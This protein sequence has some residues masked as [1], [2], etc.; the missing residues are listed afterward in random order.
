MK[1]IRINDAAQKASQLQLFT[2]IMSYVGSDL[3]LEQMF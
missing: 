1:D 3:S 2:V